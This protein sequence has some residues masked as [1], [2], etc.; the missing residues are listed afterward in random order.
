MWGCGG[1]FCC[2]VPQYGWGQGE[3]G[4]PH[5]GTHTG[6]YTRMFHLPFSDLPLKKVPDQRKEAPTRPVPTSAASKS[7]FREHALQ[8]VPPPSAAAQKVSLAQQ[9]LLRL[10]VVLLPSN[11]RKALRIVQARKSLGALNGRD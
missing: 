9:L 10:S 6:T 4:G 7:G 5:T 11:L 1:G 2:S 3:G 8:Y